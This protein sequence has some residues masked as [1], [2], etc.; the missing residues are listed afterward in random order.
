[1]KGSYADPQLL[2]MLSKAHPAN[3][4][5][6]R[7]WRRV[8]PSDRRRFN[9]GKE[10]HFVK[11][12]D[13][14]CIRMPPKPAGAFIENANAVKATDRNPRKLYLEVL[15]NGEPVDCLLDTGLDLGVLGSRSCPRDQLCSKCG[16][17]YAYNEAGHI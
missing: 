14:A 12:C 7:P 15:V 4:Q 17:D 11:R 3:W 5:V 8:C 16:Q 10:G 13:Q 9:C 6:L 1:M 2:M